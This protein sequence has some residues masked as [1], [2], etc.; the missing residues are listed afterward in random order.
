M[1]ENT[2][3]D[4]AVNPAEMRKTL[5]DVWKSIHEMRAALVRARMLPREVAAE[6]SKIAG[7]VLVIDQHFDSMNPAEPL[8]TTDESPTGFTLA[9]F[10]HANRDALPDG[11]DLLA[12]R[13]LEIGQHVEIGGG[14]VA[15]LTITRVR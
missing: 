15:P 9:Q 10:L 8:F 3:N 2:R 4:A 5:Q 12:I 7:A 11:N 1:E 13:N 6:F 14:A